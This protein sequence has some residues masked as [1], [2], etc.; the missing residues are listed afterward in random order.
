[1]GAGSKNYPKILV[2]ESVLKSAIA[3]VLRELFTIESV[4]LSL[5]HPVLILEFYEPEG[6]IWLGTSGKR[7]REA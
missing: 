1:M 2:S 4:Y 7:S 5:G 6:N 3:S